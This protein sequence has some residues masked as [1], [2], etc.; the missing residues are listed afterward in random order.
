MKTT[1][2]YLVNGKRVRTRASKKRQPRLKT[3]AATRSQEIQLIV[4]NKLEQNATEGI[5]K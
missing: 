3:A 2:Y 4:N 5:A 1:E